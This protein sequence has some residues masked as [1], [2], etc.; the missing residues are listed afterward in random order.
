MIERVVLLNLK[1][2][3]DRFFFALGALF[4]SGFPVTGKE[5]K[6]P[7]HKENI[8][9]RHIAHYWKDYKSSAAVCEA[10]A[11]DGFDEYTDGFHGYF[12]KDID[13]DREADPIYELSR[14]NIASF[15]S[16]RSALRSIVESGEITLFT[17]DDVLP[18]SKTGW[19]QINN[20]VSECVSH[21][22]VYGKFRMLNFQIVW[23]MS[24]SLREP[25]A[26][27]HRIGRGTGGQGGLAV[28]LSSEGAELLLDRGRRTPYYP[29]ISIFADV[30]ADR[31]VDGIW[32]S[33]QRIFEPSPEW[34]GDREDKF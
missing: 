11:A 12:Y 2:R 28:V 9:R 4:A 16:W 21:E 6:C 29:I 30:L 15:W 18:T 5:Y 23:N 24:M 1:H 32:H 22:E 7:D 33:T 31:I 25:I 34:N 20:L 13:K 17:L 19:R 3:E 14:N 8:I 26:E 27:S 10:A